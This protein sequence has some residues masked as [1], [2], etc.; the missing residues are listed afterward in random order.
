[1]TDLSLT[2]SRTIAAPRA[3]VFDAWLDPR[4]LAKFMRP[5]PEM[6]EPACET[7]PRTGG[8]FSI[9][10]M[11]Q[12]GELPHGGT[13]KEIS[14]HDR[15]VFTWESPYSVDD[16]TVTLD[17]SDDGDGTMVTLTHVKFASEEMR[18]N[19]EKGWGAI[20]AAQAELLQ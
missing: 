12:D 1:M 10:M 16:S 8:R 20:L 13:Y 5:A 14:P 9:L 18:D 19:H 7:D 17:F 2:T 15:I 6:P 4:L 3:R 11:G